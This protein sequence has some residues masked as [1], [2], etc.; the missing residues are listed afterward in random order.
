MENPAT[1][2][3][4]EEIIDKAYKDYWTDRAGGVTGLSLARRVADALREAN[5]LR[6]ENQEELF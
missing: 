5:L 4:A 1:W 3:L 2:G 6:D